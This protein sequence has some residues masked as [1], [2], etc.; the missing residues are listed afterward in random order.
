MSIDL[1]KVPVHVPSVCIPRVFPNIDETR[2]RKVFESLSIGEIERIDI[3]P[4]TTEKGEKFNRV[5][6]HWRYWN[7][8]EMANL[9]RDRLLNGKEIKVMYDDPW[10]WKVSAYKEPLRRPPVQ[11]P[12]RV[13]QRPHPRIMFENE[14][15][16]LPIAPGLSLQV[17]EHRVHQCNDRRPPNNDRR[18]PPRNNDRRPPPRNED[19]RRP[20]NND[21]PLRNEDNRRPLRNEDNRR[22]PNNGNERKPRPP[23]DDNR[24]HPKKE[25]RETL[26]EK[27]M[28]V[29][30][31]KLAKIQEE[32]ISATQ[33]DELDLKIPP[34]PK[35][36]QKL[37]DAQRQLAKK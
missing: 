4:K 35:K 1:S 16:R 34:I 31:E 12:S 20:P 5:F 36:L 13:E 6:I 26:E 37:K 32:V 7:A 33:E 14:N 19:N 29:I 28:A 30:E 27:E 9:S 17:Q 11:K 22:P 15:S 8:S 25:D 3:V 21:R 2:I 24:N 23:K 18:P 10:F